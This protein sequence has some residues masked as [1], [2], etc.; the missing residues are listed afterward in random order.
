MVERLHGLSFEPR[1]MASAD[2]RTFIKAEIEKWGRLTK[3]AGIE[4]E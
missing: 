4:K 1:R 2:V 3:A